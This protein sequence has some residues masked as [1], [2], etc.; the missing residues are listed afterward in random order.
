MGGNLSSEEEHKE[1]WEAL[2]EKEDKW[3]LWG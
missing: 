1:G 2:L 3:R